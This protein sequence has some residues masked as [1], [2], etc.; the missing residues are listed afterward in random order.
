MNNHHALRTARRSLATLAVD[1][2][3]GLGIQLAE[4]L[5]RL[6]I[7]TLILRDPR[8]VSA[9]APGFRAIDQ[10]RPRAE[11]AA[12]RLSS[13]AELT[14]V[15]EAFEGS[16]ICGADLHLVTGAGALEAAAVRRAYRESAAV[17]PVLSTPQGWQTGPLLV[18]GSP[19]CPECLLHLGLLSGTATQAPSRG[20]AANTVDSAAAPALVMGAAA[21]AAQQVSALIEGS[22]PPAAQQAALV[23][24]G[25]SGLIAPRLIQPVPDCAC[26]A[27]AAP[28]GL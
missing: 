2:L 6:G 25:E 28:V 7:G 17:L 10:G 4:L 14:V 23:C 3:E 5:I 24:Q 20:S 12:E 13:Q 1:G 21:A 22:A 15:L 27:A 19:I 26:F 9:E 11:A 18:P 16:S 8:P